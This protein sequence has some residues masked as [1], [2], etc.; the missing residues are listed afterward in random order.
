MDVLF[1]G[2]TYFELPI[3]VSKIH[4]NILLIAYFTALIVINCAFILIKQ[5]RI[6]IKKWT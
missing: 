6:R 5:V 2:E 4:G 3:H 1:L